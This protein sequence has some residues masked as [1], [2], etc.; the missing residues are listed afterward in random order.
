MPFPR[1]ADTPCPM[2]KPAY[3]R[4]TEGHNVQVDHRLVRMANLGAT[5]NH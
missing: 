1:I 3:D 5:P 4:E 2:Q